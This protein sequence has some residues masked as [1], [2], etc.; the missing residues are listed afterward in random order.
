V[1]HRKWTS[2]DDAN[3]VLT[4]LG[5]ND[6]ERH[7]TELISPSEAEKVL[8]A[9]GITPKAKRGEDKPKSPLDGV[10]TRGEKKPTISKL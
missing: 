6:K 2:P 10:I 4:E 3:K 5:L 1:P 9:K 8:S 7:S